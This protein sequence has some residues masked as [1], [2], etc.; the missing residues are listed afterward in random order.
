MSK[1]VLA[2]TLRVYETYWNRIVAARCLYPH[3]IADRLMSE[4]DNPARRVAK[5]RG[6]ANTRRALSD[7]RLREINEVAGTTGNDPELDLVLLR[8]H[9]ETAARRDGALALRSC[10]LDPDQCFVSPLRS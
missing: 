3:A 5:P 1:A 2:S 9:T 10:D 7:N 6:L 4:S 8:F